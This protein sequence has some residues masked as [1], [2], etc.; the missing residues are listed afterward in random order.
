MTTETN[1][2]YLPIQK[3]EKS[4]NGQV[5]GRHVCFLLEADKDQDDQCSG[6]DI[7]ALYRKNKDFGLEA[8]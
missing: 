7:V 8:F 4:K 3:Q 1:L 2:L 5:G 6:N